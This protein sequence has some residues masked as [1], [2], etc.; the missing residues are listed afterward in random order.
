MKI[1]INKCFGGFGL[2]PLAIQEIAKLQGKKCYFFVQDIQKGLS[3]KYIPATIEQAEK[4]LIFYAFTIK[5]PNKYFHKKEWSEMT[6][7]ERQKENELHNKLMVDRGGY[8]RHDP[9]LVKVVEKLKDKANG[10]FAKLA[11]VEIPDGTD[12][13]I[14]DYDGLEHIAE[15]H[16]TWR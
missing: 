13:E 1:V 12:Y 15:K 3:S 6:L 4:A 16:R 7:E 8:E 9:F 2:S 14:S 5:N 10:K 11:V